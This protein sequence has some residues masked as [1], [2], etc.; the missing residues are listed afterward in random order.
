MP[1][2]VDFECELEHRTEHLVEAG[3]ERLQCPVCGE[4][5]M[6]IISFGAS[7]RRE[8]AP[9]LNSVHVVVDK[10]SKDP[11]TKRFLETP[12]RLNHREWMKSQGLRP[13]EAGEK[14]ID[15]SRYEVDV[16]KMAD[17]LMQRHM[18]R[19]SITVR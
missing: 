3:T 8:D 17:K 9:W 15:R 1:I 19:K 5:A 12:T 10:E 7:F 2:L 18:E 11:A 13:Y 6:R 16:P 14:P 4:P